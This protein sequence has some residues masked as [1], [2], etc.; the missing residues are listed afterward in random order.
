[1][2]VDSADNTN[3]NNSS[4]CWG[5]QNSNQWLVDQADQTNKVCGSWAQAVS[6]DLLSANSN[7]PNNSKLNVNQNELLSD[8]N[9]SQNNIIPSNFNYDELYDLK[10]GKTVSN[11]KSKVLDDFRI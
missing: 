2:S 7:I 11:T 4:S 3:N 6:G 10:W 5:Q 9:G 1:M 8:E